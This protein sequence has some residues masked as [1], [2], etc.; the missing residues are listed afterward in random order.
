MP[1]SL[2]QSLAII[3]WVESIGRVTENLHHRIEI[4]VGIAFCHLETSERSTTIVGIVDKEIA[5]S[6]AI[7]GGANQSV[8]CSV[9]VITPEEGIL[10]FMGKGM[11][12]SVKR[13][14][15]RR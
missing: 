3:L 9:D 13:K 1:I 8:S 14:R 4:G 15:L 7:G 2:N 5:I 6:Q 11:F 10:V 12:M